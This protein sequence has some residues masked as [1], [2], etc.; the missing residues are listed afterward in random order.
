MSKPGLEAAA[1]AKGAELRTFLLAAHG[2]TLYSNGI[3]ATEDYL[4]KNP[5]VVKRFV[6]ASLRGWQFALKNPKKAIEDEVKFVPSL[7][8]AK[9]VA[10]IAVVK[11]LAVTPAVEKYGL[12]S[13]DPAEMKSSLDFMVKYVGVGANPPAATDLYATGFLP[14]PPVKP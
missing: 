1:K 3:V 5:D 7:D 9:S 11:D 6:R 8:P 14:N 13:F 4:A 12:G 10:E 2:L